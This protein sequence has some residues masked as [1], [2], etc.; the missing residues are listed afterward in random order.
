ILVRS[1]FR[2]ATWQDGSPYKDSCI[3]VFKLYI[4]HSPTHKHHPPHFNYTNK[5]YKDRRNTNMNSMRINVP[6]VVSYVHILFATSAIISDAV[7]D[8]VLRE[9]EPPG[10]Q[11]NNTYKSVQGTQGEEP[12]PGIAE[13]DNAV[14]HSVQ[15]EEPSPGITEADNVVHHIVQGEEPSPGV[16]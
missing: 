12:S 13:P 6:M 14:H 4:P 2:R 9:P 15:G 3:I 5:E 10:A 11:P 1:T 16:T 7:R 8:V